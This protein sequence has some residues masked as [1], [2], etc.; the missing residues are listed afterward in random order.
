M[1]NEIEWYMSDKEMRQMAPK[2]LKNMVSC[3]KRLKMT[4]E[5]ER[6]KNLHE[7]HCWKVKCPVNRY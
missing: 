4:L 3:E 6:K 5:N 7:L 1:D 2:K